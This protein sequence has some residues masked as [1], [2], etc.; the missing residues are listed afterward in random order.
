MTTASLHYRSSLV[1]RTFPK[2]FLALVIIFQSPIAQAKKMNY[3]FE[4]IIGMADL[5]VSGEIAS[6]S[7]DTSYVFIIDQT[8]KG[9]SDL[10]IKVK[11]FQNWSCDVRWK[12]PEVGQKLFLCLTRQ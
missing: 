7:G 11:M 9:K 3:P 5:I 12:K 8:V 10:K 6:V 2:I 4:V 1:I